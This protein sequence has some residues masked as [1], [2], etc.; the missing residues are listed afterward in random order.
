[1][2]PAGI[3]WGDVKLSGLLGLYL[4]WIGL[5]ALAIGLAAGFVLAALAGLALIA[6]GRATR[7]SQIAFGPYMLAGSLAVIIAAGLS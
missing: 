3:G 7:K 4:G 2:Y 6:G 5:F 1:V